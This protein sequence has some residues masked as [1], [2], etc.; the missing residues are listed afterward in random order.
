MPS[1]LN[2]PLI[3]HVNVPVFEAPRNLFGPLAAIMPGPPDIL[4]L[5]PALSSSKL[6]SIAR[7]VMPNRMLLLETANG[8]SKGD[9]KEGCNG[10]K[11]GAVGHGG[12]RK[13]YTNPKI[14][15]ADPNANSV[16]CKMR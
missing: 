2:T 15:S 13:E 3:G 6:H 9:P 8:A 12:P 7:S 5:I 14:A 16:I 10:A 4:L 1:S 11:V